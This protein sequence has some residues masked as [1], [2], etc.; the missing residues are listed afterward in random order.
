MGRQ[1]REAFDEPLNVDMLDS[2][3]KVVWYLTMRLK[4]KDEQIQE[5]LEREDN[6]YESLDR[7]IDYARKL[8]HQ[9]ANLVRQKWAGKS[10]K[11]EEE[12][13][14]SSSLRLPTFEEEAYEERD[15]K[16]GATV[17]I[18]KKERVE[19]GP[20]GEAKA[21]IQARGTGK[22]GE[23]ELDVMDAELTLAVMKYMG[24]MK[25]EKDVE[26]VLSDQDI[27]KFFKGIDLEKK[28]TKG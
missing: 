21:L 16:T 18:G 14:I 3:A 23:S 2:R 24:R 22:L 27:E 4:Q 5:M 9:V 11:E 8:E 25:V 26:P 1:K 7:L 10:V 28:G 6:L 20:I 15:P 12:E 13:L 17:E 19:A